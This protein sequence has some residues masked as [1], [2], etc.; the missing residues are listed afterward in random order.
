MKLKT[1][2]ETLEAAIAYLKG[3]AQTKVDRLTKIEEEEK[4]ALLRKRDEL[5]AEAKQAKEAKTAAEAKVTELESKTADAPDVEAKYR[6]L[7]EQDKADFQKQLD[8][9]KAEREAEKQQI[10]RAHV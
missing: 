5:L 9:M 4:P 1:D 6:S 3:E 7:Y 8:A 10:G 2:F